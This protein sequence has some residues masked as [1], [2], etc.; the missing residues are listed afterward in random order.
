[1]SMPGSIFLSGDAFDNVAVWAVRCIE[2]STNQV[3]LLAGETS[4]PLTVT[5]PTMLNGASPAQITVRSLNPR[6]AVPV[7][8]D[9]NGELRLVFPTVGA[10]LHSAAALNSWRRL[11]AAACPP[12]PSPANTAVPPKWR[13]AL[14]EHC[15]CPAESAGRPRP[16]PS[17]PETTARDPT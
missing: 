17:R 1:M 5:I 11:I 6:V 7:G 16:D 13:L 9:T 12:P 4:A 10:G 3:S 14:E 2:V 15:L 8:A